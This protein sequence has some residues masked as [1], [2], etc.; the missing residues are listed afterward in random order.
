MTYYPE[1]PAVLMAQELPGIARP[2]PQ[3]HQDNQ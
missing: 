2:I 3:K 1:Q